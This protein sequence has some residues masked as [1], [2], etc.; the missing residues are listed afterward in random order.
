MP[1]FGESFG[2]GPLTS[3]LSWSSKTD[4]DE[5]SSSEKLKQDAHPEDTRAS[6]T[7]SEMVGGKTFEQAM[8]AVMADMLP[9]PTD[10]EKA[11]ELVDA[12]KATTLSENASSKHE[13]NGYLDTEKA[14]EPSPVN[15]AIQN[16]SDLDS[17]CHC[18]DKEYEKE[19]AVMEIMEVAGSLGPGSTEYFE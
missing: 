2:L 7:W 6:T 17:G 14:E 8:A 4:K 13:A 15:V 1:S 18:G 10:A 3:W 19:N 9:S 11:D 5:A 12:L 16:S